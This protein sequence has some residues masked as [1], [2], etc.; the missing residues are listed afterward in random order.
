[1]SE[2]L[3][4]QKWVLR[5]IDSKES[6]FNGSITLCKKHEQFFKAFKKSS[7]CFIFAFITLFIPVLHFILPP[8]FI[9]IGTV[10]LIKEISATFHLSKSQGLCPCCHKEFEIQQ[11]SFKDSL[12]IFCGFCR[13]QLTLTK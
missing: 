1:M 3:E 8:V 12:K 10:L 4:E 13:E 9:I 5:S 2:N 11:Q 6:T 7:V